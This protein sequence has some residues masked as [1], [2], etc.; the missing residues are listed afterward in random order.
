MLAVVRVITDLKQTVERLK[1]IKEVFLNFGPDPADNIERLTSLCGGLLG[2]DSALY[3]RLIDDELRSCGQWNV[4]SDFNPVDKA[5]GH[6][7]YDVVRQGA[8]DALVI[9]NLPESQYAKT[10]PSISKYDLHTYMGRAVKFGGNYVG[11]LCVLY[12]R[13]YEPSEEDK[14]IMGIIASAIGVEEERK[15]TSDTSLLSQFSIEHAGDV[16]LWVNSASEI[17]YVNEKACQSLGYSREE[18]LRMTVS[19]IDPEFPPEKWPYHWAELKEKRS[20]IFES[21]HQRRDGTVFP[22]EVNVNY[23]EFHGEEYNCAF[24]RDITERKIQEKNILKRDY[25]LEIL[26]RTSQHINAVLDVPVILRTLV[27]G[28]IELVDAEGG[29]AG[30]VK[31]EKMVFSE[32]TRDGKFEPIDFAFGLERGVPGLVAKTMKPYLSNDAA[33]DSHVIPEK[34]KRFNMHNII[35]VPIIGSKGG[36]LGCLEVHNKREDELFNTED[37]YALQGLAASAATALEN[38]HMVAEIKRAHKELEALNEEL[39]KSNKKLNKL[40]VKDTQTGLYNHHYLIDV[41]EA[42]FY[43]ARRYGHRLAVVM[44]DIDYFKSINDVYGHEFGDMILKQFASHLR[45]MVRRYDVVVRYSGEEFVIVSPGLDRSKAFMM[46]QRLLDAVNLYNFGDVKHVIKLKMSAAVAAYPDEKIVKGMDLIAVAEK[47]LLKA[48]EAGGNRVSTSMDME[49]LPGAAGAEIETAD[50]K[51][52]KEKIE[53]L[54]RQ[55]RENLIESIFALAKTIELKDHHTGEHVERTVYFSIEIARVLN[56]PPEDIENIRQASILHDLGKVGISDKILFKKGKLTKREFEE[57]KQHP[58]IAADI[59]RPIQ[60]M[61]DLIP[62]VLYHH[63]RWDG[64]G[65]PAGLKGDEIPIGA[66]IIAVSDVYQA[67]TSNRPYRRAFSRKDA[68]KIIE[69]GAGTQFDPAIVKIFMG[70]VARENKKNVKR[71]KR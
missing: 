44:F 35:S 71:K 70:I 28:A 33:H 10:D 1:K 60:F 39:L 30:L 40:V 5:E 48:K 69:E 67:L 62:L 51:K 19:D 47:I 23:I 29:M 42:E 43:R 21:K 4:P 25:Q 55:G 37:A 58:Q 20:F 53:N 31:G 24:I 36:L 11:S 3:N 59:I 12:Q 26:S 6:I 27:E 15:S 54:T 7:C 17:L 46:A 45:S 64:K 14:R 66:R 38:A 61:H 50:V 9:H 65:Y 68:L 16:I 57:I 18:L 49:A 34:Q 52:L 63:E 13:D 22:V 32:Y 41:V 8:D 2:A 56:L